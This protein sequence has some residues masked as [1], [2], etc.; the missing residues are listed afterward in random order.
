MF[1]KRVQLTTPLAIAV[2]ARFNM[3]KKSH[4][5]SRRP[6][7]S[8][9][10]S[11]R[12]RDTCLDT[13]KENAELPID[14]TPV[15]TSDSTLPQFPSIGHVQKNERSASVEIINI[16]NRD[17][18]DKCSIRGN[19]SLEVH[20]FLE[21]IGMDHYKGSFTGFTLHGLGILTPD[22]LISMGLEKTHAYC[23]YSTLK[24]RRESA[25]REPSKQIETSGEL[26]IY[27]AELTHFGGD[28]VYKMIHLPRKTKDGVIPP[29][30][31]NCNAIRRSERTRMFYVGPAGIKVQ[32]S[33]EVVSM[34]KNES[35]Y[36][37]S[38]VNGGAYHI[39]SMSR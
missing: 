18:V 6:C 5:W 17:E 35:V 8:R 2:I 21:S 24:A 10:K 39:Q 22:E 7:Q 9:R 28:L 4:Y 12:L 1:M 30:L 23:I 38:C 32:M 19:S 15:V 25:N 14:H 13:D 34:W 26:N 20:Q 37:I 36:A 11:T 27:V 3:K 31:K 16:I 29:A 33:D